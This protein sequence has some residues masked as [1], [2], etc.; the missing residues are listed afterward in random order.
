MLESL[1]NKVECLKAFI[2]K[3]FQRRSS[4]VDIDKLIRISFVT[5]HLR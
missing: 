4:P 5:E 2:K 3:R 1:F